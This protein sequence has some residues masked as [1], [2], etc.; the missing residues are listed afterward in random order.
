ML[1][2][3]DLPMLQVSRAVRMALRKVEV[4]AEVSQSDRC[5]EDDCVYRDRRFGERAEK[6]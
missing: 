1:C 3:V 4:E 5:D 2:T 6:K